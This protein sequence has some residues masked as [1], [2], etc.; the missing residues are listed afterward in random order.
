MSTYGHTD[1]STVCVEHCANVYLWTH[2]LT[3]GHTDW[4]NVCYYGGP[5]QSFCCHFPNHLV[6]YAVPTGAT[7]A[8]AGCC[9]L[10]YA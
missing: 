2:R 10:K 5:E 8:A 1:W 3:Y 9:E 4:S 6:Q 7:A